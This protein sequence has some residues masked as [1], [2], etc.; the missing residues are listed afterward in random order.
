MND[1]GQLIL[2][3]LVLAVIVGTIVHMLYI[4]LKK[5]HRED[6]T[7]EE[8]KA[9]RL[10]AGRSETSADAENEEVAELMRS[11]MAEWSPIGEDEE[12]GEEMRA[13]LKQKQVTQAEEKLRQAI[14]I[15]PTTDE[16]VFEINDTARVIN[17]ANKREFNGSK[18]LIVI[19]VILALLVGIFG[20]MWGFFA[21]LIASCLIYIMASLT[22]GFIINKR[23]LKGKEGKS[24]FIS[25]LLGGV[26]GAVATAK[27]YKTVTKYTDGSKETSYDHSET[28]GA[29]I[30]AFVVTILVAS[31][32]AFIALINYLRNYVLYV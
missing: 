24:S 7:V 21:W 4:L 13:P 8:F 29:L 6:F 18:R 28:I 17:I 12:T 30:L 26:F 32:M 1:T 31:F 5:K 22:P 11:I 3:I 14:E 23:M 2:E 15:A 20:S 25:A 19:V 27:T 16:M 9:K 10:E